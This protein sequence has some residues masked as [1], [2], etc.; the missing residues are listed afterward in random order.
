MADTGCGPMATMGHVLMHCLHAADIGLWLLNA[1]L[2]SP[3]ASAPLIS[4]AMG[5]ADAAS[6]GIDSSLTTAL[7]PPAA[8]AA[9][10]A[11][12]DLPAGFQPP[13]VLASPGPDSSLS[14]A[15]QPP[16]GFASQGTGSSQSAVSQPSAG[17]ALPVTTMPPAAKIPFGDT[18]PF[19]DAAASRGG[20][21][22]ARFQPGHATQSGP[23]SSAAVP[24][25]P[26]AAPH[27]AAQS[28]ASGPDQA[29]EGVHRQHRSSV[30][31]GGPAALSG[32]S[33]RPQ[34]RPCSSLS[35]GITA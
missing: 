31:C 11:E 32:D 17:P 8:S 10:D 1:G 19:G 27:A 15:F 18:D 30:S 3:G 35:H 34:Q 9:P 4:A 5:T 7:Q 33:G 25:A 21:I 12:S 28:P 2:L 14:T 22:P 29:Q 24:S 13:T 6:P 20:A 23:Y 16:T 26:A